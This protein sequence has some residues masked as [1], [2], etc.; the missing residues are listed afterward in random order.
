MPGRAARERDC[1][2]GRMRTGAIALLAVLTACSSAVPGRGTA[3]LPPSPASSSPPPSPTSS[4]PTT[5]TAPTSTA[6]KPPTPTLSQ[7]QRVLATMDEAHRVGQLFMV[8]GD[9]TLVDAGAVALITNY[10]VGGVYLSGQTSLSVRQ[11][12]AVTAGL[13][14][15]AAGPK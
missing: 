7:A 6:P 1:D 4:A 11:T 5:S 8:D 9:A 14:Q 2:S 3:S 12:A 15:H 10:H 13:Q